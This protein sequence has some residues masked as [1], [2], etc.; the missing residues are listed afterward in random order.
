MIDLLLDIPAIDTNLRTSDDKCALQL[1]LIPPYTDGPPFALA[2]R[3]IEKGARTNQTSSES[4]D[5]ILQTLA[6][7]GL[8][9]AAVFLCAHANLNHINREGFTA[10][11]IAAQRGLPKLV[12][13]LLNNGAS[14][15][16]QSGI[17]ELKSALHFAVENDF[18]NALQIFVDHIQLEGVGEK[19]DFNLK[20]ADG[21]S[22]LSRALAL[23]R[24]S[25]VPI[26]ISGGADVNARNGQDLTLLHQVNNPIHRICQICC[27]IY[28]F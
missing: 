12:E 15:N 21:D 10:L 28:D 26:L 13:A 14:P 19:P 22:P 5:S 6:R 9:D 24:K 20:T 8:E 7:T 11:H 16:I 27:R 23:G 17:A 2:A 3:L 25:L 1:A 18:A 4:G